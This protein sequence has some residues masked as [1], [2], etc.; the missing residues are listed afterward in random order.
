[1]SGKCDDDKCDKM[2]DIRR[3]DSEVVVGEEEEDHPNAAEV[4]LSRRKRLRGGSNKDIKTSSNSSSSSGGSSSIG[5]IGVNSG[6]G[7]VGITKRLMKNKDKSGKKDGNNDDN[8]EEE[9]DN[10]LDDSRD[11]NDDN[12]MEKG[13]EEEMLVTAAAV[14]GSNDGEVGILRKDEEVVQSS[15]KNSNLIEFLEHED[16]ELVDDN[17]QSTSMFSQYILNNN[18]LISSARNGTKSKFFIQ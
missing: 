12:E 7:G 2:L 11:H 1:M 5:Y 17:S 6:S 13:D 10:L 9:S 15:G 8:D 4:A 18:I 16:I 14:A 3:K